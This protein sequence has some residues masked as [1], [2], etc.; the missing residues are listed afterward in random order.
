MTL[1]TKYCARSISL[2]VS[3]PLVG[4]SSMAPPPGGAVSLVTCA[5]ASAR[6]LATVTWAPKPID[7][8]WFGAASSSSSR[9]G[10]RFS[11]MR[12]SCIGLPVP[13]IQ[14]PGGSSRVCARTTSRT[15]GI[16][17]TLVPKSRTSILL[18]EAA[19]SSARWT[20]GSVKPGMTVR[21]FRSMTSVRAP[22][23]SLIS[24]LSPTARMRPILM[25]TASNAR[26]SALALST[27]PLARIRSGARAGC[28]SVPQKSRRSRHPKRGR[29]D[30]AT[31]AGP[32]VGPSSLSLLKHLDVG[33]HDPVVRPR[34]EGDGLRDAVQVPVSP[35]EARRCGVQDGL[36][37]AGQCLLSLGPIESHAL[38]VQ[39]AIDVGIRDSDPRRASGLEILP[40]GGAWID[41]V[42]TSPV[43]ERN[44]PALDVRP[45]RR[46][47]R[48]MQLRPDSDRSQHRHDRFGDRLV[49]QI[50]AGRRI[51]IDVETVRISGL[52]QQGLGLFRIE[53][54]ALLG[55]RVV[56]V[57][58]L[59]DDA[60]E[61]QR[62]VLEDVSDDGIAID[63]VAHR[64]ADELVVPRFALGRHSQE[65]ELG[66]RNGH[67]LRFG[68]RLDLRYRIR[69]QALDDLE[70]AVEQAHEPRRGLADDL[71]DD[72]VGR[73]APVLHAGEI[74]VLAQREHLARHEGQARCA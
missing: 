10:K 64:L 3:S 4:S 38:Q 17:R 53:R 68:L 60:V 50:A 35:Q 8:G 6:L 44:F 40:D 2:P 36:E 62:L 54:I 55:V 66:S 47:L 25:A 63:R 16:E 1:R 39:Q 49:E 13:T 30:G 41:H 52:L 71:V 9:R 57:L 20:C 26:F 11:G 48:R 15:C 22:R 58:A 5:S 19:P 59:A 21:P 46:D 67:D 73:I 51:E 34:L 23:R 14:V 65:H 32:C 45:V 42:L 12:K 56:A 70:F 28:M 43:V 37:R 29:R 61:P 18:S 27:R 7:T 24:L 33:R 31:R 69:Q 72:A 74:E